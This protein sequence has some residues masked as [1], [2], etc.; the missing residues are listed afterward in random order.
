M[1]AAGIIP[2][3]ILSEDRAIC[4][5]ASGRSAVA[6]AGKQRQRID[7]MERDLQILRTYLDNQTVAYPL[8]LL[9]SPNH[10]PI[11]GRLKWTRVNMCGL[12]SA[13]Y[14]GF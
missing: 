3:Q 7:D 8:P 1:I 9:A 11:G 5:I 6:A 13:K 4:N 10:T 12:I 2:I 14:R